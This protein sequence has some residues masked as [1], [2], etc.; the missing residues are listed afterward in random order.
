MPPTRT[1]KT[2]DHSHIKEELIGWLT[3]F[4]DA[5]VP[6]FDDKKCFSPHYYCFFTQKK[7]YLSV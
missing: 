1:H 3:L 4:S 6:L 2:R 5:K 7:L